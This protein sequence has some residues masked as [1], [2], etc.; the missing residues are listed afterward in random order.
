MTLIRLVFG[1]G[2]AL[3]AAPA[4]AAAIATTTATIST[5]VRLAVIMD[6]SLARRARS[7][8]HPLG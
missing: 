3:W 1:F 7:F 6:A 8:D 2:L 5:V 4:H